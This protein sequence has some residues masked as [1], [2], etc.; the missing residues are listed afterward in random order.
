MPIMNIHFSRWT[1]NQTLTEGRKQNPHTPHLNVKFSHWVAATVLIFC[2]LAPSVLKHIEIWGCQGFHVSWC[3]VWFHRPTVGLAY[4]KHP[5]PAPREKSAL[6]VHHCLVCGRVVSSMTL[7]SPLAS[8]WNPHESSCG[9]AVQHLWWL[10]HP[11]KNLQIRFADLGSVC[12]NHVSTNIL[13][14]T[15]SLMYMT[16]IFRDY[17]YRDHWSKLCRACAAQRMTG[18]ASPFLR[19]SSAQLCIAH[20]WWG[21]LVV[22]PYQ[23]V[24][25][26]NLNH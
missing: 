12:C 23:P 13:G 8:C 9:G 17:R 3:G 5:K 2:P 7:T 24:S 4:D 26:T 6:E 19:C 21:L 15:V 18:A 14:G 25:T 11:A 20:I 16:S 1:K 22:I 10:C